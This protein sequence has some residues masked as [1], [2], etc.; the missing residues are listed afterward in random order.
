VF[1]RLTSIL[2]D[3]YLI[4]IT[5]RTDGSS[6]F[7]PGKQ[8][9]T[10]WATGLGWIFSNEPLI[11]TLP[12]ISFGKLRASYG[13]TGNDQIGDYK[14]LDKWQDINGAYMGRAGIHPVQLADSNYSWEVSR[15]LEAAIELG[16]LKDRLMITVAHYRHRTGNQLI[17]YVLPGITGFSSYAAKNSQALVQNT[18]WEIQLQTKNRLSK[19]WQLNGNV[20]LTIP[21]NKLIAFPNLATSSYKTKLAIGQSLSVVNKYAY[22]GVN[23]TTGVFEVVDQ[24]DDGNFTYPN[25]YRT[26]G[27]VDP[28][29]YGSVQANV[30]YKGWQLDIFW[31]VRKQRASS[32]LYSIYSFN[33][34]GT[35][36]VNQPV[37]V[38]H[39]WPECSS[40]SA[41][42]KFSTG[43]ND[44]TNDATTQF[45][46]S[47]GD[48]KD[49]SFGRLRNIELS[50]QLP[51]S[52]MKNIAMKYCRL[53]VQAQN[54]FTIT[55]YKG[56][57]PETRNIS[58]LPPLRT[59]A[60]GIE[61]SF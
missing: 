61:L 51:A 16:L 4:N 58:T 45:L 27:N 6:R 56:F 11:K 54:I 17:A 15:K 34:P 30:Q 35:M 40:Q 7:G 1:A 37:M 60:A 46:D 47:D 42:Q 36:L 48:I 8:V 28:K 39:R 3:K 57:D 13:V 52:W 26:H 33:Q 38:L 5:G 24:D 31:E 50:W 44:K 9:G 22:K 49:V 59:I 53:Y 14:Y 29:W 32:Y 23:S 19:S 25:D 21:R 18:G 43:A 41:L 12:F 20:L 2:Y 10:F 55:R